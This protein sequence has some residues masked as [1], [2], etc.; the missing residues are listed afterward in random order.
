MNIEKIE[1]AIDKENRFTFELCLYLEELKLRMKSQPIEDPEDYLRKLRKDLL[2]TVFSEEEDTLSRRMA[3]RK[4]T[5]ID[6]ILRLVKEE[7][8]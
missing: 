8:D 1:K 6:R 7:G 2:A 3:D 4:V 5:E